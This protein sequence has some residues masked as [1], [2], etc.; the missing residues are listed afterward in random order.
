MCL[1]VYL[2]TSAIV[3]VGVCVRCGVAVYLCVGVSV[4]DDICDV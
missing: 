1:S 3:F 2:C 4:Y